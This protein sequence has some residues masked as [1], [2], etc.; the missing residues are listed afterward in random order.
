MPS[1]LH[2]ADKWADRGRICPTV[3]AVFY[4]DVPVLPTASRAR[5]EN[6]GKNVKMRG[7]T[8]KNS[9]LALRRRSSVAS[10]PVV[11]PGQNLA[12]VHL[13]S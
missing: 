4:R 1:D 10:R 7:P 6:L 11:C 12:A 2:P 13:L 3:E 8:P 5:T 9:G